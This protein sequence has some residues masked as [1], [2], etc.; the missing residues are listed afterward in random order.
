MKCMGAVESDSVKSAREVNTQVQSHGLLRRGFGTLVPFIF[1]SV[2]CICI[3]LK[4]ISK[5]LIR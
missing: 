4:I 3:A 2:E 5:T 1:V